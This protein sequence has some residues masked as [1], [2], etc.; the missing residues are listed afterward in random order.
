MA[1]GL[2]DLLHLKQTNKVNDDWKGWFD[3]FVNTYIGTNSPDMLVA[4]F[5][6]K[7]K[8]D[9]DYGVALAN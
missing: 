3:Q 2:T 4:L 9:Q 5:L 8:E 1:R 6:P 7:E